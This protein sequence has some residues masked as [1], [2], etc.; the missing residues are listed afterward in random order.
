M[1]LN[2]SFRLSGPIRGCMVNLFTKDGRFNLDQDPWGRNIL[3]LK[4]LQ[5]EFIKRVRD[6]NLEDNDLKRFYYQ[7][8]IKDPWELKG[9]FTK[10]KGLGYPFLKHAIYNDQQGYLMDTM[11]GTDG[12]EMICFIKALGELTFVEKYLAE[13]NK[14]KPKIVRI[15]ISSQV[16]KDIIA[17]YPYRKNEFKY[18]PSYYKEN[19]AI[20]RLPAVIDFPDKY[21]KLVPRTS[22]P[23]LMPTQ[24]DVLKAAQKL[25]GKDKVGECVV[26]ILK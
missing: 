15:V 10:G 7:E 17:V 2:T 20:T 21:I 26:E 12:N 5:H 23:E 16:P 8:H 14:A 25:C 24:D 22:S 6:T 1:Y 13:H 18:I 9:F 19:N 11:F 4:E 3:E